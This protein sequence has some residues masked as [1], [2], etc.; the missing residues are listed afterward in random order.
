[1]SEAL[2]TL[3]I[4]VAGA[5]LPAMIAYLAGRRKSKADSAD[6]IISAA[7][8]AVEL[9]DKQAMKTSSKLEDL[10][11]KYNEL[12]AINAQR[13]E[14]LKAL[15]LRDAQRD[16]EMQKLKQL[17]EEQLFINSRLNQEIAILRNKIIELEKKPTGELVDKKRGFGR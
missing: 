15:R 11:K 17:Y 9:V 16:V 14:E 1:M 2:Q 4:G 6:V 5:C 7:S 12:V 13:E 3:L 10:E 8:R